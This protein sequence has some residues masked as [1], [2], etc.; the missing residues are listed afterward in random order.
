MLSFFQEMYKGQ[1]CTYTKT[2]VNIYLFFGMLENKYEDDKQADTGCISAPLAAVHW[3]Q[4]IYGGFMH[5]AH[6]I[7]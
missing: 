3:K 2:L 5:I 6:T 7:K 4:S 1:I